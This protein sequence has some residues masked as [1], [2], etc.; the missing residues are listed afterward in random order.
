[1]ATITT[2]KKTICEHTL[3]LEDNEAYLIQKALQEMIKNQQK[4]NVGSLE[5]AKDLVKILEERSL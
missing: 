3:V 5:Y 2:R 1:M 4:W